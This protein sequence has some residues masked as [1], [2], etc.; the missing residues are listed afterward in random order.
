MDPISISAS[1]AGLIALAG[2]VAKLTHSYV[3]G[4]RHAKDEP[5]QFVEELG[6]LQ[7]TLKSL[8]SFLASR[9][10][11]RAVFRDT[12]VF[13]S[14]SKALEAKLTRLHTR[15]E[16]VPNSRLQ[17]L[18]WPLNRK[19]CEDSVA[20]FRAFAQLVQF[21]LS[22]DTC[23]LLSST[24][25]D[26]VETLGRQLQGLKLLN[27]IEDRIAPLEHAVN[28][29]SLVLEEERRSQD[30]AKLLKWLADSAQESQ[31][32]S[33]RRGRVPG[34]GQ[35]LLGDPSLL[36]WKNGEDLPNTIWC[37]GEMGSGK[38]KLA[39]LVIDELR[40]YTSNRI[41]SNAAL[42]FFYFNYTQAHIQSTPYVIGSLLRQLVAAHAQPLPEHL[43][44]MSK[45]FNKGSDAPIGELQTALL[46]II[47]GYQRVYLIFDALD[48]CDAAQ[49][50]ASFFQLLKSLQSLSKTRVL[51]ASRPHQRAIHSALAQCPLIRIRARAS[52]LQAFIQ[53]QFQSKLISDH[54]DE[55]FKSEVTQKLVQNA[56]GLFLLPAMQLERV[57]Q[58]P[59]QGDMEDALSDMPS[60]LADVFKGSIDRIHSQPLSRR[61]LA[62]RALIWLC[63][64]RRP[65]TSDELCEIL[66]MNIHHG[67]PLNN[68][69][70]PSTKVIVECCQG[71]IY[72]DD[73]VMTLH[74]VHFAVKDYLMAHDVRIFGESA[75][76]LVAFTSLGYLLD[77]AFDSGPPSPEAFATE[78]SN[79][80][81]QD[82]EE[83]EIL[84]EEDINIFIDKH[85]FFMYLSYY[86]GWHVESFQQ[87][88]TL[89]SMLARFLC[90][91]ARVARIYQVRRFSLGYSSRY[92]LPKEAWS[93]TGL[94]LACD[95]QLLHLIRSLLDARMFDVDQHSD[96]GTTALITASSNNQ[97]E[98]V[99]EL[100]Q[101]GADP[102]CANWY[103]NSLHCAAE[104]DCP[105]IIRELL[106]RGVDPNVLS[107]QG[108]TPLFCT[109]DNDSAEAAE[110][111]LDRGASMSGSSGAG[112]ADGF[113]AGRSFAREAVY[114]GAT[115][116]IAM[117][118]R[119]SYITNLDE[120]D[121]TGSTLL[122]S[123][124]RGRN[125]AML[126]LLLRAG[127][128]NVNAKSSAGFAPIDFAHDQNIIDLLV[129]AGSD[130]PSQ[131]MPYIQ[132][133]QSCSNQH[134]CSCHRPM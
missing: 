25:D 129:A 87:D 53:Y 78:P 47:D 16:R 96:L 60:R 70:R 3:A 28:N 62:L 46:Q 57:L 68:K 123:A 8:Q 71:L 74:L 52:D 95:Y 6:A 1:I 38:T 29:Q 120:A 133:V 130:P 19:E 107:P 27:S 79:T 9:A 93:I 85:P 59:T 44:Q 76:R 51:V 115:F 55:R 134:C 63:Q 33:N 128:S 32:A 7:R 30:R 73:T 14:N 100:L 31:H 20:E 24:S 12:S 26:V 69:Y 5:S 81:I 39:S 41:S 106:D 118:I 101:R 112:Q 105:L 119:K 45:K 99:R 50:Q 103:G 116:I 23:S 58:E 11:Q 90:S 43:L 102:L 37:I 98:V 83:A 92:W 42:A 72:L 40:D 126:S 56:N 54:L 21:A 86:W 34:T 110:M 109:L 80:S 2:S 124:A 84:V 125:V 67:R 113:W 22:V 61:S 131:K 121:A 36:S 97:I 91:T 114:D 82:D 49:Y 94:Q 66:S 4:V 48:E 77:T 108:R 15:L 88:P 75:K 65:L 132:D 89:A 104:A 122:H 17:R 35:W 117:L 18:V 64:A 127:A 111:L 13:L 10:P